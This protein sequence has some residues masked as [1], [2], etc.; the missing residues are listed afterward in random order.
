M[1][2]S[3][4]STPHNFEQF[5]GDQVQRP[6]TH[7]EGHALVVSHVVES[8]PT[9]AL[10]YYL[11]QYILDTLPINQLLWYYELQH[12]AHEATEHC[13]RRQVSTSRGRRQCTQRLRGPQRRHRLRRFLDRVTADGCWVVLAS[14]TLHTH[15]VPTDTSHACR[16]RS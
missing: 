2:L 15:Y 16:R 11:E 5:V 3:R 12:N 9:D 6:A 7:C 4:L 10:C 8:A 14:V 1:V 13:R